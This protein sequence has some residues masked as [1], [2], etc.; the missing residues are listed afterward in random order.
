MS[1]DFDYEAI[2]ADV[3]EEFGQ[4]ESFEQ[5]FIGFCQNAM[6][7]KA[8]DSDLGRLIEN[9]QLSEEEQVDEA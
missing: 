6:E 1:D 8:E 5:R 9:V 7:G 3:L 4:D 2:A